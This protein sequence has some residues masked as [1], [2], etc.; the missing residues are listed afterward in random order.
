MR[1]PDIELTSATH[2]TGVQQRPTQ[3]ETSKPSRFPPLRFVSG[4]GGIPDFIPWSTWGAGVDYV[5][6]NP[7][8]LPNRTHLSNLLRF[9]ESESTAKC[10]R[11]SRDQFDLDRCFRHL[12]TVF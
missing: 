3:V 5:T 12:L 11:N 6:K 10:D 4:S 8:L 9:M 1:E 2:K 7:C